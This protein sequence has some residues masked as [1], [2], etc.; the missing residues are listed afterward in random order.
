MTKHWVDAAGKAPAQRIAA[1]TPTASDYVPWTPKICKCGYYDDHYMH[2]KEKG[3][4]LHFKLVEE[5]LD[6]H[7]ATMREGEG[8]GER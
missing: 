2:H 5:G 3:I 8:E 6:Y 1:D 7:K 4:P